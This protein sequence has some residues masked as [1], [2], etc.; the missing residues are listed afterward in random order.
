MPIPRGDEMPDRPTLM[1]EC[2]VCLRTVSSEDIY[3]E[4]GLYKYMHK[5]C[6]RR[7]SDR[8]E[9]ERRHL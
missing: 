2:V 4:I 9:E 8:R 1:G 6:D 3:E 5:E 7:T